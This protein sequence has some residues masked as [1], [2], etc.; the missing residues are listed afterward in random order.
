M[1][2]H[3]R[4]PSS[5][6]LELRTYC[7]HAHNRIWCTLPDQPSWINRLPEVIQQLRERAD[8][9]VDRAALEELLGIGRRRAQQLLAQMA[10]RRVGASV[11]ADRE[12]A[13]A[14]LEQIAAGEAVDYEQRRRR[15]LWKELEAGPPRLLVEVA[16]AEVRRIEREDF[17]GLPEGVDLAP[18]VITVRFRDPEEALR[19]L[20]ALA[21]AI[22]G[23]RSGF[24]E[25]VKLV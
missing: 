25:R 16:G 20:M 19:K 15:R 11:V 5:Q 14:Y 7:A 3:L 22:G 10:H 2:V 24:E 12:E 1:E 4:M 8:P 9:W 18:G 6:M 17:A 23:N 21:L 13:A